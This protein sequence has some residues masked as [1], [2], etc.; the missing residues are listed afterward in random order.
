MHDMGINPDPKKLLKG[1]KEKYTDIDLYKCS[2]RNHNRE[3][4]AIILRVTNVIFITLHPNIRKIC[5]F[6][7]DH[8]K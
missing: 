8:N 1:S 3:I 4:E 2:N 7:N 6:K 5:T